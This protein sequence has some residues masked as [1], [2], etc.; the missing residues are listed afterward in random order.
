M[1]KASLSI[2]FP[3]YNDEGTVATMI[4]KSVKVAKS[5]TNDYEI[6]V[7][8]DCSVDNGGAIA[9]DLAQKYANIKRK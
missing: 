6:I 9:D 8:D 5:I 1:K 7:V 2:F 3:I 4:I